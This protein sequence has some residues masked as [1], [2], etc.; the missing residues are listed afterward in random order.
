VGGPTHIEARSAPKGIGLV[1]VIGR[2]YF[3]QYHLCGGWIQPS[4]PEDWVQGAL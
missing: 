1:Q 2:G 4:H 3:R